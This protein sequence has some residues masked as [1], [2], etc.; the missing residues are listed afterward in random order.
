M[1]PLHAAR[2]FYWI[3]AS[4]GMTAKGIRRNDG[5]RG[6]R[7]N[8]GQGAFAGMTAKGHSRNDGQGAFAEW[9][10]GAFAGMTAKGHSCRRRPASAFAE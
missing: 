2:L 3:P 6:I 4:A 9:R 7:R 8:D 1:T 5:Q 10:Q